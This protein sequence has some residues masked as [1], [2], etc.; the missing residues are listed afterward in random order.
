MYDIYVS[1]ACDFVAVD[2]D[3]FFCRA[4]LDAATRTCR[5]LRDRSR[6]RAVPIV[7]SSS[8]VRIVVVFMIAVD[9]RRFVWVRLLLGT[10][11]WINFWKP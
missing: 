10:V 5:P 4:S 7:R 6:G 9:C 1:T 11:G 8:T 2:S 3:A